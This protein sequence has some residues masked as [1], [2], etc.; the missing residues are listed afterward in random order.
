MKTIK[1][2]VAFC[3]ALM[4]FAGSFSAVA[5]ENEK[6]Y[7][8]YGTYVL[9]GDSVASGYRDFNYRDTEFKFA[10]DSYSDFVSK[11]LG[12]ELIP[13]AC[14][15]FRTVEMRHIFEDD[16]VVEDD[17]LFYG[18]ASSADELEAKIPEIRK[19][20]SEAGLITLGIGGNDW[21]KYLVWVVTDIME[22]RKLAEDY[23]LKLRDFLKN[24]SLEDDV[25]DKMVELADIMNALP[26]LVEVVPEAVVYS[27]ST[28]LKNWDYMIQDIYDLNPDVTLL[29]IGM[30]DTSARL[31]EDL[32]ESKTAYIKHGISKAIISAANKPMIEGAEKFGYIYVDTNGA[33]FETNHPTVE[34]HRYIA[35]RILEALPD[36]RFD[37]D[38]VPMRAT[39]YKAA[40]Y[41]CINGI[42]KGIT[43]TNFGPD[44]PLTKDV[45]TSAL[46]KINGKDETS[47]STDAVSKF[48]FALSLLKSADKTDVIRFLRL[49]VFCVEIVFSGNGN[50]TRAE[51]AQLLYEYA[52]GLA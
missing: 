8:D 9:L 10:P 17:Y 15:G 43:E 27:F 52:K 4:L 1:K 20:V 35:D 39:Y 45:L 11:D 33:L 28:Y 12:V 24:A 48:D 34:G 47:E 14:P 40:E 49:L 36:A 44:E 46:S 5:V 22:K 6:V 50:I 7:H 3:L 29:V 18:P 19:A 32:A 13:M 31:E 42:M 38:D 41:M 2:V 23:V 30:Y 21:G 26:E 25:I 37:F 16:Y 51:A